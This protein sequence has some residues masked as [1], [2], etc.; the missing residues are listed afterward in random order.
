MF[1]VRWDNGHDCGFLP[2][3]FT[4]ETA[5]LASGEDWAQ[6]MILVTPNASEGDYQYEIVEAS[7][8][9]DCF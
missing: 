6:G 7:P 3:I 5:A 4:T 1:K 9:S 2:G 8:G